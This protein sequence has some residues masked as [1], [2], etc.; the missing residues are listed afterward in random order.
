MDAV[1]CHCG[2]CGDYE[3]VAIVLLIPASC[4]GGPA[5]S[6]CFLSPLPFGRPLHNCCLMLAA[7]LQRIN[8]QL[9]E[10]SMQHNIYMY[11]VSRLRLY[12]YTVY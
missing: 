4:Q 8:K 12:T 2:A 6:Q 9:K 7:F 5:F 3:T 1:H 10:D 11:V